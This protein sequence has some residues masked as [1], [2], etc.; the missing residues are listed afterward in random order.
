[1][2]GAFREY[3]NGHLPNAGGWLDQPIK[4]SAAME[5]IESAFAKISEKINGD[6]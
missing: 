3:R 6:Q 1:M 5:T 4:Y 2:I